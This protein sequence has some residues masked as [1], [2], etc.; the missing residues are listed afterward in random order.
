MK[1]SVAAA[2]EILGVGGKATLSDVKRAY[3]QLAKEWHPDKNA[4]PE[5]TAKFQYISAARDRLERYIEE[6]SDD[7]YDDDDDDSGE[8]L[9]EDEG[10]VTYAFG[11]S[12]SSGAFFQFMMSQVLPGACACANC[13]ARFAKFARSQMKGSKPSKYDGQDFEQFNEYAGE[14]EHFESQRQKVKVER[15]KLEILKEQQ[16]VFLKRQ[17]I[18]ILKHYSETSFTVGLEAVASTANQS[19]KWPEGVIWELEY[20]RK[21]DKVWIGARPRKGEVLVIVSKLQ[22]GTA[23]QVHGRLGLGGNYTWTGSAEW[24]S[25]GPELTITTSARTPKKGH[26]AAAAAQAKQQQQEEVEE[27]SQRKGGQF[28]CEVCDVSPSSWHAYEQHMLS[29]KHQRNKLRGEQLAKEKVLAAQR[30]QEEAERQKQEQLAAKEGQRAGL[31]PYNKYPHKPPQPGPASQQQR[32]AAPLAQYADFHC[33]VCGVTCNGPKTYEEHLVSRKHA[34]QVKV[35]AGGAASTADKAAAPGPAP[36]YKKPVQFAQRQGNEP[37]PGSQAG[38]PAIQVPGASSLSWQQQAALKGAAG[39]QPGSAVRGPEAGDEEAAAADCASP[40]DKRAGAATTPCKFFIRGHCMRG[41]KCWFAHDVAE[42]NKYMATRYKGSKSQQQHADQEQEQVQVQ[43]VAVQHNS[44]AAQHELAGVVHITP[45]A[46]SH[47]PPSDLQNSAASRGGA[48]AAAAA[49]PQ[50]AESTG[51]ASPMQ[52]PVP[53]PVAMPMRTPVVAPSSV[54]APV[55]PTHAF[56]QAMPIPM[57]VH[58]TEAAPAQPAVQAVPRVTAP[59]MPLGFPPVLAAAQA[60]AAARAATTAPGLPRPVHVYM[61]LQA[62]APAAA[63]PGSGAVPSGY[64][65]FPVPMPVPMPVHMPVP[66]PVPEP[67]TS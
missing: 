6:G 27:M 62:Q 15:S 34:L 54:P 24:Q 40:D 19:S 5:A 4:G 13:R 10:G 20:K 49:P 38:K 30:E 67:G 42:R 59:Y 61:P 51:A 14:G 66:M 65:P 16:Q 43:A 32:G 12:G 44:P 33:S 64:S 18:V 50:P 1:I 37:E 11:P 23:Y 52:M 2:Q 29:T 3:Y 21:C 9:Y 53:T 60:A 39:P 25:W 28:Y 22:P 47:V 36:A 46:A 55:Q 41:A 35:S 56:P 58:G 63:A 7:E 26:V 17:A 48:T 8:E 45:G 57:P 31:K